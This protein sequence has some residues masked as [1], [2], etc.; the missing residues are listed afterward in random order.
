MEGRKDEGYEEGQANVPH[1]KHRIHIAVMGIRHVLDPAR[2]IHDARR[3]RPYEPKGL[4]SPP[5]QR[6]ACDLNISEIPYNRTTRKGE[7]PVYVLYSTVNITL[8]YT[9][10]Y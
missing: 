8:S 6:P 1:L 7:I 2:S 9:P 3:V 5:Q 10:P 4:V